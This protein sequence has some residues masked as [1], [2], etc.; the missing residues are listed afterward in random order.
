[1][2]WAREVLEGHD[3]CD[4]PSAS[5]PP[6]SS[7]SPT[8]DAAR[9][10]REGLRAGRPGPHRRAAWQGGGGGALPALPSVRLAPGPQLQR[11]RSGRGGRRGPGSVRPRVSRPRLAEGSRAVRR[12][13]LHHRAQPRPQLPHFAGD[14]LQGGRRGDARVPALGGLRSRRVACAGEG[15]GAA[16]G[17]RGD[18]RAARRAGEGDR[19]ALLPG[20]D[21]VGARDRDA[22]GGVRNR[23]Y[24]G[25]IRRICSPSS[26]RSPEATAI[27]PFTRTNVPLALPR[28]LMAREPSPTMMV[29]CLLETYPSLAKLTSPVPRPT[30]F[31]PGLSG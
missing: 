17:A 12:L 11:A 14:A 4:E 16:R 26:K 25:S 8:P 31:S 27:C 19:A 20:G 21:A 28:S 18:R 24:A 22:D 30:R 5:G 29:A 1:M 23:F 13:A 15:S 2:A 3:P 9:R 6:R 7:R 10:A